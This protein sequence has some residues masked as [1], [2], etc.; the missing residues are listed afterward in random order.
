MADRVQ[1]RLAH[2]VALR[3]QEPE[4]SVRDYITCLETMMRKM[5]PLP[6][7]D[8]QLGTLHRNMKPR[9]QQLIRRSDFEDV[10]SLLDLAMQAELAVDA[11]KSFKPPPPPESCVYAQWVYKPRKMA[12]PKVKVAAVETKLPP[13]PPS[14]KTP[15][16]EET[17]TVEEQL[18]VSVDACR[19][20]LLGS[21]F[22]IDSTGPGELEC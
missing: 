19:R 10:E 16:V 1:Q 18:F 21:P 15:T 14:Q 4:E 13:T 22:F 20:V 2:E 12:P 9:L 7:L 11:E 3:T 17:I 8:F 5:E 6:S